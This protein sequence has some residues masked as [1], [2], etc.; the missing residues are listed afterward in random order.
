[1]QLPTTT[2]VTALSPLASRWEQ[3]S[4]FPRIL[5]SL[6][7]FQFGVRKRDYALYGE[8]H[9]VPE[10]STT[11]PSIKVGII[12]REWCDWLPALAYIPI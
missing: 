6:S 2:R 5:G 4:T 3:Y 1:M 11:D 7:K 10:A 9:G 12:A 8:V